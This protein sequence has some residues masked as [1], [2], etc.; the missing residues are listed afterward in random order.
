[1]SESESPQRESRHHTVSI[2]DIRQISG[3]AT[4]H[5]ALQVR[6]RIQKLIDELPTGDPV[7]LA[8]EEEIARLE[9]LAL[10]G[11]MYSSEGQ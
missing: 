6:K 8:G 1:M 5:F 7:R 10:D 3:A 4:P 11:A 9:R 2:D